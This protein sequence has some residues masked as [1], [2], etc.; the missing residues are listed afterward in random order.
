[1][2]ELR[3]FADQAGKGG[4]KL[5]QGATSMD[6][7][8]NGDVLIF[9]RALDLILTRLVNC[10]A[11]AKEGSSSTEGQSAWRGRTSSLQSRRPSATGSRTT[12][13]TC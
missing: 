3:T 1:M 10:L 7:E 12:P 11:A 5:H 13:R 2:A 4:G 6:I 8:D 9:R